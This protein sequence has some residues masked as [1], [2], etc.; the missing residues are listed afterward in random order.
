MADYTDSLDLIRKA[1]F[2]A[3][4]RIKLIKKVRLIGMRATGLKKA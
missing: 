3:L 1:A 2:E 4:G